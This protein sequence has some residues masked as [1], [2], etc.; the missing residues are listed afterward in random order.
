MKGIEGLPL[1]YLILIL[2]AVIVIGVVLTIVNQFSSSAGAGAEQLG[3]TLDTQLDATTANTC[4][5]VAGCAWAENTTDS[6]C[7]CA[8]S[9]CTSFGGSETCTWSE[10]GPTCTCAA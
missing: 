10:T 1:K 2:V 5:S 6:S 4:E 7:V 9:D 8:S 3:D